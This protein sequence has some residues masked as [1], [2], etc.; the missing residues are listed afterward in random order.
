MT[1]EYVQVGDTEQ[2]SPAC[3]AAYEAGFEAAKARGSNIKALVIC[4]PHNPLGKEVYY[5]FA[6]QVLALGPLTIFRTMLPSGDSC[7]ATTFL[8]YKRYSSH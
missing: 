4:N 5:I 7:S 8:C 3:V 6:A 2:F 1:L